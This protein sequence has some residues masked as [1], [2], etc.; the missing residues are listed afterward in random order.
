MGSLE[1][2]NGERAHI[3]AG[4]LMSLCASTT[5]IAGISGPKTVKLLVGNALT[6]FTEFSLLDTDVD[7]A[8][9][10]YSLYIVHDGKSTVFKYNITNCE[11]IGSVDEESMDQPVCIRA[12]RDDI[13][14]VSDSADTLFL[15]EQDKLQWAKERPGCASFTVDHKNECIVVPLKRL[16]NSGEN[17]RSTFKHLAILSLRGT[18]VILFFCARILCDYIQVANKLCITGPSDSNVKFC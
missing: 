2:I 4:H 17:V 3:D 15:F 12:F 14:I 5:H 10:S 13:I 6:Q 11:P 8:I 16:S 1:T 9:P 18:Y 7:L